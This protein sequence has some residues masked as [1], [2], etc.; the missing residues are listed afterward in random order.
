MDMDLWWCPVCERAIT[1]QE[2]T[3]QHMPGGLT[4]PTS[5]S[6][7]QP[8]YTSRG[9]VYGPK[10]SLYC[11]EACREVEEHNGRFAFEQLAA[12]LPASLVS[13]PPLSH[14]E[15]ESDGTLS[16]TEDITTDKSRSSL[17]LAKRSHS[18]TTGYNP[19]S[20]TR[21]IASSSIS[22]ED[23][24]P[25]IAPLRQG[26]GSQEPEPN[27]RVPILIS[28]NGT[29]LIQPTFP[30]RPALGHAQRRHQSQCP[31]AKK[32]CLP[33][34]TAVV[35]ASSGL[36]LTTSS[37]GAPKAC[38]SVPTYASSTAALQGGAAKIKTI[39]NQQPTVVRND[40]EFGADARREKPASLMR[41]YGLFFRSR[42][43]S[44][45]GEWSD[46]AD[47]LSSSTTA[48]AALVGL[49]VERRAVSSTTGHLMSR[50]GSQTSR[51]SSL[52]ALITP[53]LLANKS[54]PGQVHKI[55]PSPPAL[56]KR[57]SPRKDRKHALADNGS[58][59]WTWDH[60][61][62]DVPQYP[63]M[64]LAQIRLSKLLLPHHL[65]LHPNSNSHHHHHHHHHSI[66]PLHSSSHPH[67]NRT[68]PTST[69]LSCNH[70]SNHLHL[71]PIPPFPI[72]QSKK[73]LFIFH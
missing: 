45:R 64:D 11:S 54:E 42:S 24:N 55:D 53:L 10:G 71:D 60:L 27:R 46:S 72:I 41:H 39:L 7:T 50:Q 16:G 48:T 6:P 62:A 35:R 59:S 38:N 65:T 52:H 58:R 26:A 32:Y 8:R 23:L 15:P 30:Q 9:G 56:P 22:N 73:K 4:K 31:A 1:E 40:M 49:S 57:A 13:R 18:S 2:E 61:P 69:H 28:P 19:R 25:L 14:E 66:P 43:G 5:L 70:L 29:P 20:S 36:K 44:K 12:C 33:H 67:S 51:R 47:E 17:P 37:S 68:L 21:H 34:S 63:A 3:V